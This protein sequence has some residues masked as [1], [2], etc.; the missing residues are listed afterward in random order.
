MIMVSNS[1]PWADRDLH[2]D[3]ISPYDMLKCTRVVSGN[4]TY[5]SKQKCGQEM[6][7]DQ[8]APA[9]KI[10]SQ[11]ETM[12]DHIDQGSIWPERSG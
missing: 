2:L 12:Q 5:L 7:A 4:G 9:P 1:T 3:Q 11:I 8:T 6:Y 10:K